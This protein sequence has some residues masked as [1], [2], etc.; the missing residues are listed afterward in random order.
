MKTTLSWFVLLMSSTVAIAQSSDTYQKAAQ[1]YENAASQ[2]QSPAGA[3]CMRQNASYYGCLAHQLQGGGSC[4]SP[5]S[6]S[7]SCSSS[8]SGS[9]ISTGTA[10]SGL[11]QKQQLAL[12][13]INLA[14]TWFSNHHK[15]KDEPVPQTAEEE[16]AAA[17]QREAHEAAVEAAIAQADQASSDLA[18]LRTALTSGAD[19][20]TL[21]ALS[22][23][24]SS[25]PNVALRNQLTA[26][27]STTAAAPQQ[28]ASNDPS[29]Q[30]AQLRAQMTAQAAQGDQSMTGMPS[31]PSIQ[32][33]DDQEAEEANSLG[34]DW[35]SAMS[36][37]KD[38]AL[39]QLK[40]Q[41]DPLDPPLPNDDYLK[42]GAQATMQSLIPSRSESDVTLGS[43]VQDKAVDM[44]SDKVADTLTESKDQLACS[45]QETQVD[46]NGC[47]V[48][49]A[50]TNLGRGL[51]N[52]G[53]ILV[54]RFGTFMDSVNQEM[55]F[56]T[57]P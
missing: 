56:P 30:M 44:A 51:Y 35:G 18:N 9:G 53:K 33:I 11:S 16:A 41:F 31:I 46:K 52:Y 32:T 24:G 43:M 14:L 19:P 55:Q 37:S 17:A 27:D 1:A 38:T 50:P 42:S 4:S 49:M 29:D 47:M 54:N 48:L 26:G 2:C 13:G 10:A 23:Q 36:Q 20:S 39:N 12:A 3:S 57:T 7:T 5:P 8:G 25:D 6:C 34:A 21:G 45:G 15:D 22:G 28:I 40:S